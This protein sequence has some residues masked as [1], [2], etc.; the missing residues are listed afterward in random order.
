VARLVVVSE[1]RAPRNVAGMFALTGEKSCQ[2]AVTLSGGDKTN[3]ALAQIVAGGHNVLLLDEQTND[4]D[5]SSPA[6]RSPRGWG[7]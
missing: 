6:R 3:F 1:E 2:D 5:P 4:L 7:Q